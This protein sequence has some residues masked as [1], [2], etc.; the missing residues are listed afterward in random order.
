MSGGFSPIEWKSRKSVTENRRTVARM[1]NNAAA[2][3]QTVF[4]DVLHLIRAGDFLAVLQNASAMA[5]L[6][7]AVKGESV[8]DVSCLRASVMLAETYD[9]TSQYAEAERYLRFDEKAADALERLE[10]FTVQVERSTAVSSGPAGPEQEKSRPHM[11]ALAF[12][13]LQCAIA[14]HRRTES[15]ALA[16][17]KAIRLAEDAC[18]C[19][20]RLS[21]R[22]YRFDGTLSMFFYWMGRFHLLNRNWKDAREAFQISMRHEHDNLRHHLSRHAGGRHGEQESPD[23]CV[24]CSNKIAYT[25]YLLA[26]N[27][28]FGLALIE[29]EEGT[30]EKAL[31]LLRPAM[32]MLDGSTRD[33]YRK[34]YVRLLIGRAERV[35][36][37]AQLGPLQRALQLLEEARV[38]FLQNDGHNA[39]HLFYA[40]RALHQL[41]IASMFMARDHTITPEEREAALLKA[42][43]YFIQ[44]LSQYRREEGEELKQ[45]VDHRLEVRL[46]LTKTRLLGQVLKAC[47]TWPGA[48][49][50]DKLQAWMHQCSAAADFS[51]AW[52]RHGRIS[53]PHADDERILGDL[54]AELLETMLQAG[55]TDDKLFGDESGRSYVLL[56]EAEAVAAVVQFGGGKVDPKRIEGFLRRLGVLRNNRALLQKAEETIDS[57]AWKQARAHSGDRTSERTFEAPDSEGASDRRSD[58]G[59]TSLPEFH[60]RAC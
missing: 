14:L 50:Q 44:S 41:C 40:A 39:A 13:C 33:S 22:G 43:R 60:R 29:M 45:Y 55:M 27:M 3:P 30:V 8:D 54:A 15:A 35:R 19:L 11:R 47:A 49:V 46:A 10:A 42:V 28:A 2:S 23:G 25:N 31:T 12:F 48:C 24:I 18:R 37:G 51:P 57:Q 38:L 59:P 1:A 58:P 36:A 21:R 16:V 56:A 32:I 20:E 34:G 5:V 6:Q 17:R 53:S 9:Q 7:Q 52:W 4:A 26:S